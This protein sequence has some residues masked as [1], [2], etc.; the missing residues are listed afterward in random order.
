MSK[1]YEA[2]RRHEQNRGAGGSVP[3]QDDGATSFDD[4]PDRT[5]PSSYVD[6]PHQAEEARLVGQSQ[7]VTNYFAANREMQTLFRAVEPLMAGV[8]GGATIMFSSAHPGEGKTTVCGSY[9]A[10]LA[11]SFGK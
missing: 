2:L 11:Q 8:Q 3:R 10:T 1:I 7:V 5:A 4:E 6:A 9:A